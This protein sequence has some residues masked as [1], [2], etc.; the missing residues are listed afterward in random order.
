MLMLRVELNNVYGRDFGRTSMTP[1]P[2]PC[3]TRSPVTDMLA[4]AERGW[5]KEARSTG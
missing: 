2:L 1:W 4:E 3:T 5:D